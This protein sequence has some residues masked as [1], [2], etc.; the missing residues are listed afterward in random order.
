MFTNFV[1][2]DIGIDSILIILRLE[3]LVFFLSFREEILND[4][5]KEHS[6]DRVV[7]DLFSNKIR[8]IMRGF[9]DIILRGCWFYIYVRHRS[10]FGIAK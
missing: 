9:A 1:H 2:K 10:N 3:L 6:E 8:L 4:I 5:F 7:N